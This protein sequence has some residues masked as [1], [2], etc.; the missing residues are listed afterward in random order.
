MPS[1][2]TKRV[3]GSSRR[4]EKGLEADSTIHQSPVKRRKVFLGDLIVD[5]VPALSHQ[6]IAIDT[7]Q[8]FDAPY[9]SQGSSE[10]ASQNRPDHG[11]PIRPRSATVVASTSKISHAATTCTAVPPIADL[12]RSPSP[13]GALASAFNELTMRH[14]PSQLSQKRKYSGTDFEERDGDTFPEYT[15]FIGSDKRTCLKCKRR[16]PNEKALRTHIRSDHCPFFQVGCNGDDSHCGRQE[17]CCNGALNPTLYL[18]IVLMR[19]RIRTY[20]YARYKRSSDMSL[21]HILHR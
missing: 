10:V 6:P 11:L 9:I 7:S 1:N 2:K 17:L 19:N 18:L 16:C 4:A 20:I 21:W 12:S 5:E 3:T 15:V 14:S 13:V 8:L